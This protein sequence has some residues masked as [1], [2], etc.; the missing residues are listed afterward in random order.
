MKKVFVAKSVL[1]EKLVSV[2]KI[3]CDM[4]MTA[5]QMQGRSVKVSLL[6]TSHPL[7][8]TMIPV[9]SIM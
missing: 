5:D 6:A 8:E 4:L 2:I 7:T 1:Y 3:L 9:L